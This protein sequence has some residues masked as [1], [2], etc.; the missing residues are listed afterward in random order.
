[1]GDAEPGEV[2]WTHDYIKI[3]SMGALEF[4]VWARTEADEDARHCQTCSI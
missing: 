4:E 2:A 3:C 1:M